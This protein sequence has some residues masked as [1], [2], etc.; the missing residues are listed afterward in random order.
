M[1][2]TNQFFYKPSILFIL[3]LVG[4]ELDAQCNFPLPPSNT[5]ANAPL[6]CDLDGYCSNNSAATNSGTPNA[7]CG[8]VENNNWVSFIAGSPTFTLKIT[9]SNCNQNKGLQAQIFA[10]DDC[11]TFTAV[12][13]CIDPV[14]TSSTLTATGLNIGQTYYLMMD[15]KGGDVCDYFLELV[16]GTTLS[17]AHAEIQ[18]SG[19]LC[20]DATLTLNAVG[21]STNP[22]LSYQWTTIDGHILSSADTP[23]INIDTSGTYKIVIIDAGGCTDSTEVS[24]PLEPNPPIVINDPEI[25]DCLDNSTVIIQAFSD[26]PTNSFEWAGPDNGIL[27]GAMS[28]EV[29][30]HLPGTYQLT[31]THETTG[32]SSL[33]SV[34]VKADTEV[35]FAV[36]EDREE[37]NCLASELFLNGSGSSEGVNFHY[38][39]ITETGHIISEKQSLHPLIDKAGIYQLEVSN[40]TNGCKDTAEVLVELNEE[41]P[42]G[43]D[44]SV[45]NPCYGETTGAILV[46]SVHGGTP[47]YLYAFDG[48]TFQ[49]NAFK[50]YLA[51]DAYQLV[52][53][54]ATGCEWD[55]LLYLAEQPPLIVTLGE[56]V[57]VDLGEE[58]KLKAL[59]NRTIEEIDTVIWTPT[60]DCNNCLMQEIL[61][62]KNSIYHVKVID[63]N[64][65]IGEDA[66]KVFLDR[67]RNIFIPNAFSPNGDGINDVFYINGGKGIEEVVNFNIYNRWGSLVASFKNFQPNDPLYGWDGKINGRKEIESTYIYSAEIKFIDGQVVLFS[68]DVALIR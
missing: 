9:V 17:P 41:E 3:L 49:N 63:P 67:K 59:V 27:A 12:S 30:V 44:F 54:D 56:D 21:T 29:T 11:Q 23:S 25:L 36:V 51:P 14:T 68:G 15:G 7:F 18:A 4:W 34:K 48:A 47:P 38:L 50:D 57:K 26:P 13:N 42:T 1:T 20:Q 35:P 43:A 55:T 46:H 5:C 8:E 2:L 32:C 37:L 19:V 65:C 31:V 61:P 39:W 28:S 64:G 52:I 6:L 45:L 33:L 66:I 60:F 40:I 53:Q 10:T 58:L 16:S 24:I 22:N 62:L